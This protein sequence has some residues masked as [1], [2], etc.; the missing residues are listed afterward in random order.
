ML[1]IPSVFLNV[2]CECFL[3]AANEVDVTELI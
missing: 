3:L 1:L 2:P